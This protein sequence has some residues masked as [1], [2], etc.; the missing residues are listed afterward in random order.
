MFKRKLTISD[1]FLIAVNLVPVFGV[2]FEGWDARKVFIVYCIETVIVG[3]VTILKMAGI[4]L[5]VRSKHEWNNNG[6]KS[7]QSG[8]FFILFFIVHY[9]F[10]VFV[11]TQIFFAVT[12]LGRSTIGFGIYSKIP[13]MLGHEGRLMVLI[14]II[15]YTAQGL[16]NF[17]GS[18]QYKN[19]SMTRLMMQPYVRIFIQ[20]FIVILGGM[21]LAFGA[22][23]LFIVVMA[24]TRL[25]AELFVDV[26]RLTLKEEEKSNSKFENMKM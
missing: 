26:D 22:P 14:F 15:Y 9:G 16:F 20:Q 21:M 19:I 3:L 10:F 4:T 13:G 25:A 12:N 11:Q 8:L 18:G 5:F 17:F 23:Y 2:W 1:F 6:A 24:V 7:M